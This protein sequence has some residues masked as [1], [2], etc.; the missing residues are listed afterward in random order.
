L[1]SQGLPGRFSLVS[2]RLMGKT[3]GGRKGMKCLLKNLSIF[4]GILWKRVCALCRKNIN[5]HRLCFMKLV[6]IT[7][8]FLHIMRIDCKLR[9]EVVYRSC[10]WCFAYAQYLCATP[11]GGVL[12][13][14]R[15]ATAEHGSYS[16]P[17]QMLAKIILLFGRIRQM[18]MAEVFKLLYMCY[19]RKCRLLFFYVI[20]VA[21]ITF[22]LQCSSS[23]SKNQTSDTAGTSS[24]NTGTNPAVLG[25]GVNFNNVEI[26]CWCFYKAKIKINDKGEFE[27]RTRLCTTPISLTPRDLTKKEFLRYTITDSLTVN[28][29]QFLLFSLYKTIDTISARPDA[30]FAM[31]FRQKQSKTDTLVYQDNRTWILNGRSSYSYSFD[32]LD[33]VRSIL[34]IEAI[35]CP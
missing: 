4:I 27:E 10:L 9:V 15:P 25:P 13:C 12:L 20:N 1:K 28:R 6:L 35:D 3:P 2:D 7:G 21:L 19:I 17:E 8:A 11:D 29:L 23:K 16:R 32:V 18:E 14:G 5:I 33:T 30:R 24:G 31:L 26:Y 34:K 22:L